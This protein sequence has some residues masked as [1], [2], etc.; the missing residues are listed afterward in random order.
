MSIAAGFASPLTER[1]ASGG[2]P[3]APRSPARAT[4]NGVSTAAAATA[5]TNATRLLRDTANAPHSE[6]GANTASARTA[7]N[8]RHPIDTKQAAKAEVK[9]PFTTSAGPPESRDHNANGPQETASGHA[10]SLA[11]RTDP[12]TLRR[13]RFIKT[14]PHGGGRR[15]R[16]GGISRRCAPGPGRRPTAP[17]PRRPGWPTTAPP[18]GPR[19]ASRSAASGPSAG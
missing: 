6:T 3:S 14:P 16:T 8:A 5:T 15:Y 10:R 9:D 19:T 7:E 18:P 2:R 17:R 13:V 12:D 11:R 4:A 1:P